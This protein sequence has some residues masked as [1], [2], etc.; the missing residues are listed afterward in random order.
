MTLN[1]LSAH[2]PGMTVARLG[3]LLLTTSL[4]ILTALFGGV[5]GLAYAGA[6]CGAL[7]PGL[8]LGWMLFGRT[9]AGTLAGALIGYALSALAIWL[10][11]ALQA[12]SLVAIG[13]AWSGLT[14]AI[15]L[16][17]RRRPLALVTLPE[18][19]SRT[20][21]ALSVVMLLAPAITAAPYLHIGQRDAEGNRRYRAYFTADFVWHEALTAELSRWSFPP[22]N[23]YMASRPLN[24]YWAYYL[25]PATATHSIKTSPPIE[26]FLAINALGTA[27]LFAGAI[28]L[29]AWASVPRPGIAG[30]AVAVTVLAASIEGLY[31]V[32]DLLRR[33]RP[34]HDPAR[35]D[36][37]ESR[38]DLQLAVRRRGEPPAAA[39]PF[40][41]RPGCDL[42]A[43]GLCQ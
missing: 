14:A 31:A 29:F 30:T 38:A 18:W 3:A 4:L 33:D 42:F 13:A 8:P 5:R 35:N 22:R 28:F 11:I 16:G 34:V 23:P 39:S 27:T 20:T 10:P 15:W 2:R 17:T 1:A 36:R 25:L 19:T 21:A 37:E 26:Q 7:L 43:I 9:P 24:Y 12:P 40:P 32:I 6:Y 41:S